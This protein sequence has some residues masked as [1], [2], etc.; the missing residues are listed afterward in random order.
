MSS[1]DGQQTN[2]QIS[3][4]AQNNCSFRFNIYCNNVNN[5]KSKLKKKKEEINNNFKK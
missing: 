2:R 4:T 3:K 1:M 5:R